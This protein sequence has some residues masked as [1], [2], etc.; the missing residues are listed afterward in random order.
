MTKRSSDDGGNTIFDEQALE[1]EA[2]RRGCSVMQLKTLMALT[3][4]ING[5]DLV[6]NWRAEDVEQ[7]RQAARARLKERGIEPYEPRGP[8]SKNGWVEPAPL[9]P[10]PGSK[11]IDE[12]LTIQ[13][14]RDRR[15]LAQSLGVAEPEYVARMLGPLRTE[16]EKP[17]KPTEQRMRRS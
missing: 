7:A 16:P 9:G 14:A 10:P 15:A 4:P 2:K 5:Q 8:K 3:N 13:E 12:M 6:S 11:I 1:V 17:A